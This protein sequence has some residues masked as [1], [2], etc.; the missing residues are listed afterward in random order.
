MFLSH[1][2]LLLL[3]AWCL[4]AAMKCWLPYCLMGTGM[5]EAAKMKILILI[6]V[7]AGM[8]LPSTL[9]S[10][11]RITM[12][13]SRPRKNL[14]WSRLGIAVYGGQGRAE[15]DWQ[16]VPSW[17][18]FVKLPL[19]ACASD[20]GSVHSSAS[21]IAWPFSLW[22]V[23]SFFSFHKIT[24][25]YLHVRNGRKKLCLAWFLKQE[26]KQLELNKVTL[27]FRDC[28]ANKNCLWV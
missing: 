2:T 27:L 23:S 9:P 7:L 1:I 13:S 4:A 3:T 11:A 5:G 14:S 12:K 16:R 21:G 10:A 19:A 15:R 26:E 18:I 28:D 22:L 6:F 8:G 25:Q 20:N 17:I 24:C